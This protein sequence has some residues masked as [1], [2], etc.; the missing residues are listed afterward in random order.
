MMNDTFIPNSMNSMSP[1]EE[2]IILNKERIIRKEEDIPNSKT[3][4]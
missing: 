4:N 2:A 1:K 3:S